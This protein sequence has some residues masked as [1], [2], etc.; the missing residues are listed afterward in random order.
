MAKEFPQTAGPPLSIKLLLSPPLF[1]PIL[2]GVALLLYLPGF[3]TWAVSDDFHH[4]KGAVAGTRPITTFFRPLEQGVNALNVRL[5]GYDDLSFSHA[6]SFVGFLTAIACVYGLGRLLHPRS[7]LP[8]ALAASLLAFSSLTPANVIQI[9]TIS[10][11]YAAV[12]VL[13]FLICLLV[14]PTHRRSLWLY[15]LGY[16]FA[17]LALLAKETTPGL[18][19]AVP[20]AALL[21]R[22]H[23]LRD[24]PGRAFRG[25]LVHYLGVVA[26]LAVYLALRLSLGIG[27][28][29]DA[30]YDLQFSPL[31][32]LKN[33]AFLGG[34][35]FYIGGSTL[36]LLPVL[37]PGRLA[38]SSVFTLT[39]FV[40]S[41]IG[42]VR[43]LR[44]SRASALPL[45]GLLLLAAAGMFP[46]ALTAQVHELYIYGS[47]PFYALLLGICFPRG[48]AAV[49]ERFS[50]KPFV[51][52]AAALFS[53]GLFAWLAWGSY[54]KV[55]L[56]KGLTDA[57]RGYFEQA[58]RFFETTPERTLKLCW[59]DGSGMNVPAYS[60]FIKQPQIVAERALGFAAWLEGRTIYVVNKG[61]PL[62]VFGLVS[63]GA[64]RAPPR[65]C[66]Y[67][68]QVEAG[69]LHFLR[70]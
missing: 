38:L 44:S 59:Q 58:V 39:L 30:Q 64:G 41:L 19:A 31:R 7:P 8:A 11:Q 17:L 32:V 16:L 69:R 54:E 25:A 56:T 61:E 53:L 9:D 52:P 22:W 33:V 68:L 51:Y 10:Q 35:L 37:K 49:A 1:L 27:L 13:L 40:T 12:F 63:T 26:V 20:L 15:L 48:I 18:V 55:T 34:G 62:E 36:D 14:A 43:L 24:H 29:G 70:R 45:V 2:A 3:A 50:A 67:R 4:L 57:S 47:L 42:G 66:G 5:F 21:M 46:A 6:V 60:M 23:D 65:G 28:S